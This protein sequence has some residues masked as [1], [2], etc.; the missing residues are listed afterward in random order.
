LYAI[1]LNAQKSVPKRCSGTQIYFLNIFGRE[2]KIGVLRNTVI[3]QTALAVMRD[4][5]QGAFAPI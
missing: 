4:P 3:P 2:L 1:S 5:S